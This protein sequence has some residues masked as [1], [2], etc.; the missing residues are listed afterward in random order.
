MEGLAEVG[1]CKVPL[2]A[3]YAGFALAEDR[4]GSGAN[5]ESFLVEESLLLDLLAEVL[6][7]G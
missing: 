5:D 4:A 7:Q 3:H 6:E 1:H 2:S